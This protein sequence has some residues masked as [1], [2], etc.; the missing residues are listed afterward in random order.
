MLRIIWD[1]SESAYATVR[2]MKFKKSSLAGKSTS[3]H[4]NVFGENVSSFLLHL[5]QFHNALAMVDEWAIT[6]SAHIGSPCNLGFWQYIIGENS[7]KSC[8]L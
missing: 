5:Y 6:K 2:C 1:M 7:F 8:L 3:Y 4:V